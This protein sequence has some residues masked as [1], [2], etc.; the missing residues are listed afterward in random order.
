MKNVARWQ[1]MDNRE[2][3]RKESG[4]TMNCKVE[5]DNERVFFNAATIYVI[6][7]D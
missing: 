1:E 5:V 2:F 6:F 4:L 7:Y 3:C